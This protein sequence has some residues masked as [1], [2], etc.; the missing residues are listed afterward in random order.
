MN[1]I[2]LSNVPRPHY[3]ISANISDDGKSMTGKV[4][5]PSTDVSIADRKDHANVAHQL[6][7]LWN[8]AHL[9]T[10]KL[11]IRYPLVKNI[12]ISIPHIARIDKE[13]DLKVN[14]T[15]YDIKRNSVSGKFKA[16]FT[17]KNRSLSNIE[18]EF[19]ALKIRN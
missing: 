13:I 17:H 6:F 9:M 4:I 14:I 2:D 5:F 3:L 18:A 10:S 16:F 11:G 15:E 8:A 1:S 12:E 19:K 7:A